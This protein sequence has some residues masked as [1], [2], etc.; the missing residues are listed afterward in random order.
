MFQNFTGPF[1]SAV[2]VCVCAH[3]FQFNGA[4]QV[5]IMNMNSCCQRMGPW[6]IEEGK[7][8]PWNDRNLRVRGKCVHV[9]LS[10]VRAAAGMHW[11]LDA[12]TTKPTNWATI[13]PQRH[14]HS[15]GPLLKL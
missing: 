1:V 14:L 11:A 7:A 9:V 10:K 15:S 6:R 12:C 13:A 3:W 4:R 2:H 8:R 5:L